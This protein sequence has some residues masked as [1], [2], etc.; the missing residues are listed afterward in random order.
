MKTNKDP[1]D[2]YPLE[3]L[4]IV[5]S[6]NE[7]LDVYSEAQRILNS[8]NAIEWTCDYDLSGTIYDIKKN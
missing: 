4:D 7:D 1:R 5:D 2:S 8:L 6:F 3:V